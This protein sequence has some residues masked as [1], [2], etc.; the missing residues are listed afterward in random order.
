MKIKNT[1]ATLCTLLVCMNLMAQDTC[2]MMSYNIL[3]FDFSG[4]SKENYLRTVIASEHPDI[5]VVQELIEFSGAQRFNDSVVLKVDTNYLMGSFINSYD[6]DNGIYFRKDKFTFI[7]NT[8]ISTELRDINQFKLKHNNSGIEFYVFSVHLKASSGNENEVLR[9]NESDSLR[10]V[11]ATFH[12]SIN[13]IVTGDFNIYGDYEDAYLALTDSSTNGYFIDPLQDSLTSTWN[14]ASNAPYHTQSTR[15]RSFGGG[16]TGGIDD[17][18]DLMLHSKAIK[19]PGGMEYKI[20]SLE[21]I[22]NDGD[23]YND[24]INSLP[25]Y[26][27]SADVINAIYYSSD[28][29][30]IQEQFIFNY[31][32]LDTSAIAILNVNLL[33]K[34]FLIY[35]NPANEFI[36]IKPVSNFSQLTITD[37]RGRVVK[38]VQTINTSTIKIDISELSNGLYLIIVKDNENIGV[39]KFIK[40]GE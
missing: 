17:R 4:N 2:T 26:S 11:T 15:V 31:T 10:K 38:H 21:V 22:G 30:P 5:L 33:N 8:P 1:L 14:N 39:K 27:A 16:S 20:G 9:K 23:H 36:E 13:Y 34:E 29:L 6:T 3:N 24:S 32:P 12:D 40:A 18:F 28:H 25:N 19:Q 37:V 7:S 35:P